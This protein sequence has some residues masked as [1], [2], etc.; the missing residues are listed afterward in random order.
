V[1]SLAAQ[2]VGIGTNTPSSKLHVT[3]AST[4]NA[5]TIRVS[6][7][8]S[9]TTV[10]TNAADVM[11]MTDANGILRRSNETVKDAWTL[12]VMPQLHCAV[13]E[14]LAINLSVYLK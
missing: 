3:D 10:T 8:S 4:P 2:N 13:L 12:Q 7:L 6:G 5:A 9:T 14:Q 1:G 11:V